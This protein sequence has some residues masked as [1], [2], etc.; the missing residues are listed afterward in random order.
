[1][2][3]HN[4]TLIYLEVDSKE[5]SNE[6]VAAILNGLEMNTAVTEIVLKTGPC[7]LVAYEALSR[8]VARNST[9]KILRL[10]HR[11]GMTRFMAEPLSTAM[12]HDTTLQGLFV[13]PIHGVD[14]N[15]SDI[16][17]HGFSLNF[18][19]ISPPLLT[20]RLTPEQRERVAFY[21]KLNRFGCRRLG[22]PNLPLELW[23]LILE[24]VN[25]GRDSS[26]Y[27]YSKWG[28]DVLWY[29]INT[30]P[31]VYEVRGRILNDGS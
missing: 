28:M 31:E 27:R 30:R 20:N 15:A 11:S 16:F 3:H 4:T 9:L 22:D 7:D 17:V 29:V 18:S 26:D 13:Y 24:K 14:D 21:C 25:T 23:P 1:M 10:T 5:I 12:A 8:V 2:L 6:L 19:I